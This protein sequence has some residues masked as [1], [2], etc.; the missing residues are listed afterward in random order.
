[1]R[2]ERPLSSVFAGGHLS[3]VLVGQGLGAD[4]TSGRLTPGRD[5]FGT[6][7]G[8]RTFIHAAWCGW[9][10]ESWDKDTM[11]ILLFLFGI[12]SHPQPIFMAALAKESRGYGKASPEDA[13]PEAPE[14][15]E[16]GAWRNNAGPEDSP[17]RLRPQSAAVHRVHGK[18]L[19]DPVR[20][21]KYIHTF[22]VVTD[23]QNSEAF[24]F[25]L[26]KR[27]DSSRSRPVRSCYA[28]KDLQGSK[29]QRG[30]LLPGRL[31]VAGSPSC[32]RWAGSIGLDPKG[33][34]PARSREGERALLDVGVQSDGDLFLEGEEKAEQVQSTSALNG[35]GWG[36]WSTW[37]ACSASCGEAKKQRSRGLETKEGGD[38]V[39]AVKNSEL[40]RQSASLW[41]SGT[42]WEKV[43]LGESIA[44]ESIVISGDVIYAISVDRRL[45]QQNLKDLTPSAWLQIGSERNWT[46]VLPY[47]G[48]LYGISEKKILKRS[49]SNSSEDWTVWAWGEEWKQL[50]IGGSEEVAYGL[51]VEGKLFWQSFSSMSPNSSWKLFDERLFL[52]VAVAGGM[53]YGVGVD[54]RIYQAKSEGGWSLSSSSTSNDW[55]AVMLGG[56]MIYALSNDQKLS[57]QALQELRESD[58]TSWSTA[59]E[60]G[61]GSVALQ[62]PGY[63]YYTL[64][65]SVQSAGWCVDEMRFFD[66]TGGLLHPVA[67]AGARS[68]RHPSFCAN[69][70]GSLRYE[71][72]ASTA[73][74]T[75]SLRGERAKQ[76]DWVLEGSLDGS[77]WM[78][79]DLQKEVN[80][81]G[82]WMNF[83]IL[84][85]IC[86]PSES[87]D[88]QTCERPP[89]PEDCGVSD[90]SDWSCA[91]CASRATRNRSLLSEAQ[92]GGRCGELEQRGHACD[93]S[94]CPVD[95]VYNTWSQW[96]NCPVTCSGGVRT[97][98]RTVKDEMRYG[99]KPCDG[100]N[101][102]K[103]ACNA[104]KC[105]VDC[106]WDDWGD[107]GPC[108]DS[109]G[110]GQ[111]LR[112][113]G[114]RPAQWGGRACEGEEKE[115]VA[116]ALML[117]PVDCQW[118]DWQTWSDCSK[119][120]GGG[121]KL[122][123]RGIA[124]QGG[125]G[126]EVCAP[127]A[128]Q[129]AIDCNVLNC[130]ADCVWGTWSD[131]SSC[132]TSCGGGLQIRSR[133]QISEAIGEGSP[134]GGTPQEDRECNSFPCPQDCLLGDWSMWSPCSTTCGP[135]QRYKERT[136]LQEP[137]HGGAACAPATL[138]K[139]I[140]DCVTVTHCE[141]AVAGV[142]NGT[143]RTSVAA[144]IM[145]VSGGVS[146]VNAKSKRPFSRTDEAA[147]AG[148]ANGTNRTSG[149]A[150]IM[151]VSGGVSPVN[152]K[153]KRPFS[154]TDE[155]SQDVREVMETLD[156]KR[157]FSQAVD[158]QDFAVSNQTNAWQVNQTQ[159]EMNLTELLLRAA[160]GGVSHCVIYQRQPEP[161]SLEPREVL[162]L[163]PAS[164]RSIDDCCERCSDFHPSG[165]TRKECSA[166]QFLQSPSGAEYCVLMSGLA[167]NESM[168]GSD[169]GT[170]LVRMPE[171]KWPLYYTTTTTTTTTTTMTSTSTTSTTST[172]T[173]TT[174]VTN[175]S[176]TTIVTVTNTSTA[177]Y[178]SSTK[179]VSTSKLTTSEDEHGFEEMGIPEAKSIEPPPLERAQ[180]LVATKPET[181]D[182]TCQGIHERCDFAHLKA[183]VDSQRQTQ[184]A[185]AQAGFS[186]LSFGTGCSP[187]DCPS[188]GAPFLH[189]SFMDGST[190]MR[191]GQVLFE[192][193]LS[194][195]CCGHFPARQTA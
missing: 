81:E 32:E 145:N 98:N 163:G 6:G 92:H 31:S 146:P 183:T 36:D 165:D 56:G 143:N 79:L 110:G 106:A 76:L 52:Q 100:S 176:T 61:F 33:D 47:R 122:R 2:P 157:P 67:S 144:A 77:S 35:C 69:S 14:L 10:G 186:C 167:Y 57:R 12:V 94:S 75:Y 42:A 191:N 185:F 84:S 90:W 87:T 11:D 193:A 71:F 99:G 9:D 156:T 41:S 72:E 37:S 170:W 115:T 107:F 78:K 150:A 138:A 22:I 117:C 140:E 131:W 8:V 46:Q 124:V 24:F 25:F 21:S 29:G 103:E 132:G 175:T 55:I 127:D 53:V 93:P 148:A 178:G 135:G 147:V 195:W 40:Y 134:C 188:W 74:E 112:R 151:N 65:N 192:T 3:T 114:T 120:C 139:E 18:P 190:L 44:L 125:Y 59:S 51:S 48:T 116:C 62:R 137:V 82:E 149:A 173:E 126:G 58:G 133:Q 136:H 105:P 168:V 70:S 17:A 119:P 7:E 54:K 162:E 182:Q 174:S 166:I 16:S 38:V 177:P 26:R 1:M 152:A 64:A 159:L 184:I 88:E 194:L 189:Q 130:S 66:Q 63:T 20:R 180:W 104:Q 89:C 95:C 27:I 128:A 19:K 80:S 141:A 45:H 158:S 4:R 28:L 50:A 181:C 83:P 171:S 172:I 85:Q 39:Y 108:S 15:P 169:R 129:E 155:V 109:C 160:E 43:F 102:Q 111:Q 97:R 123:R 73:V 161:S 91:A 179:T 60:Q 5:L 13:K 30:R 86:D 113:R 23:P 154:R 164:F 96:S 187:E 49:F 68:L 34:S 142:A 121:L 101:F 118:S 153:S